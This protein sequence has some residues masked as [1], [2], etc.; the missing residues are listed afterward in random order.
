MIELYPGI[1][2]M[3]VV[4]VVISGAVFTVRGGLMLGRS[5][6]TNHSLLKYPSYVN[7]SILLT[8]GLLLMQI[9]HQYPGPQAWLSV[10]LSLL[11]LYIVLGIFA[12]R[13]ARTYRGRA[14]CLVCAL[15][16][17]LFMVSIARTHHPLGILHVL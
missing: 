9:T 10:K 12:L 15:A 6:L 17:Y 3:H 16:V 5:R 11:L 7:D 1:K 4:C 13:R 2:L 8:T 14:A